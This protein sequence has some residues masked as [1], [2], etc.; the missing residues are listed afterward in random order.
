MGIERGVDLTVGD[1]IPE[2]VP[3]VRPCV[4]K[5]REVRMQALPG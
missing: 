2:G 5:G 3:R 4:N 1:D